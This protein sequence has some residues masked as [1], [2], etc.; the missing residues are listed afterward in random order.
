MYLDQ[1]PHEHWNKTGP[2]QDMRAN[3]I[4]A[5]ISEHNERHTFCDRELVGYLGMHLAMGMMREV[6]SGEKFEAVKSDVNVEE[7]S[8]V[9]EEGRGEL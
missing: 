8:V 9:D 2:S 1:Q 6:D 4:E 7:E 3:D 5:K